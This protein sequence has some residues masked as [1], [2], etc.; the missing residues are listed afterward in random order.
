MLVQRTECGDYRT[1]VARL[2][3]RDLTAVCAAVMRSLAESG[4][5]IEEAAGLARDA[6][7]L[8]GPE[9]V[10]LPFVVTGGAA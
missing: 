6:D 4:V 8:R 2:P 9:E 3:R 10:P 7:L 1:L 5:D